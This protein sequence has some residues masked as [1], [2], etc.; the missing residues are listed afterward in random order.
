MKGQQG[1]P[2]HSLNH[3]RSLILRIITELQPLQYLATYRDKLD[4][5]IAWIAKSRNRELV[6]SEI[7]A[8]LRPLKLQERTML[9]TV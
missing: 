2:I 4:N 3:F 1:H 5:H 6:E 8:S 7:S 9:M